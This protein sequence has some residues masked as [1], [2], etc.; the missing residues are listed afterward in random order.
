MDCYFN[1]YI[2]KSTNSELIF[3]PVGKT[4]IT[5]IAYSYQYFYDP[6]FLSPYMKETQFNY[7][8]NSLN[9]ELY[10]YWPCNLC[11]YFGYFCSPCTLGLSFLC[12]YNCIGAAKE[13]FEN[14]LEIYNKNHFNPKGLHLSYQQHCSTSWLQLS[15]LNSLKKSNASLSINMNNI[16]IANNQDTNKSHFS[17]LND[18][19]TAHNTSKENLIHNK[20]NKERITSDYENESER[21][22]DLN[23]FETKEMFSPQ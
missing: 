10:S 22:P 19:S 8:M 3:P 12:P 11:F 13:N 4:F 15:I 5:G 9:D 2:P 1:K 6:T 18:S 17:E 7:L 16:K 21:Q 14:K 20:K 23:T